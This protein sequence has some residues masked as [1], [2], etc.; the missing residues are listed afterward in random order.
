VFTVSL[1][2]R[3]L[4][5]EGQEEEEAMYGEFWRIKAQ[6]S[7]RL[8]TWRVLENKIASKR[9]LEKRGISVE[10]NVCSMCGEGEETTSHLFM[11]IF[12]ACMS[13]TSG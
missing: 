10:S 2:Y 8:T 7:T 5:G 12:L 9:N 13:V 11:Q 1:A 3:I 6:P 4:R